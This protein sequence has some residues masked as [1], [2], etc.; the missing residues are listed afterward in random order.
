[1]CL[2]PIQPFPPFSADNSTL[3]PVIVSWEIL[4]FSYLF[5]Y[6]ELNYLGIIPVAEL[7]GTIKDKE[8]TDGRKAKQ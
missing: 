6:D 7:R 8:L 3:L 4:G 1:M 2:F 5:W